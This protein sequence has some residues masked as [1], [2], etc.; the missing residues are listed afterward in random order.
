M[1]PRGAPEE[2][3]TQK[4]KERLKMGSFPTTDKNTRIVVEACS[5]VLVLR[6]DLRLLNLKK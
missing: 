1:A 3:K 6:F 5:G 2:N 4:K